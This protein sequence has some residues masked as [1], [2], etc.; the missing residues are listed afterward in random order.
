MAGGG[1][2]PAGSRSGAQSQGA[3]T[4]SSTRPM[5]GAAWTPGVLQEDQPGA[6]A[7][8]ALAGTGAQGLVG[9][10]CSCAAPRCSEER[11]A[12]CDAES[13]RHLSHQTQHCALSPTPHS[14]C[15]QIPAFPPPPCRG[16]GLGEGAGCGVH[17]ARRLGD[18]DRVGVHRPADFMPGVQSCSQ[19]V[20]GPPPPPW[21]RHGAS[22][23]VRA[24]PADFCLVVDV[25]RRGVPSP[26]HHVSPQ[27]GVRNGLVQPA[28]GTWGG[29]GRPEATAGTS[30][31]EGGVSHSLR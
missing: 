4:V 12:A 6:S 11:R 9:Q 24:P 8:A 29:A 23:A 7:A 25:S 15:A 13:C 2:G 30:W 28:L 31:A 19:L 14:D 10:P 26:H 17:V 18:S 27:C 21:A 16:E 3:G 1:P 20:R 5:A 22:R